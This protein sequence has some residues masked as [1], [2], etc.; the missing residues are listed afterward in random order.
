MKAEEKD[1][2]NSYAELKKEIKFLE[3]K[4]DELNPK[5]LQIME[6]SGVEE[7]SI[8][9]MGKISLGSR[10]TWKYTNKVKEIDT[11]LKEQKD[12]EERVGEA[13]YIEKYYPI[14]KA[15]KDETIG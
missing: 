9:D 2:L 7:I 11:Q 8:H 5:V 10:R 6:D 14:F 1:I 15:Q 3:S 12:Y 13:T 4:A